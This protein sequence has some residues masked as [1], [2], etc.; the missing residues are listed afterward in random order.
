MAK[1]DTIGPIGLGTNSFN[2][3]RELQLREE[4]ERK[5]LTTRKTTTPYT[6]SSVGIDPSRIPSGVSQS[7]I[8]FAMMTPAA[9]KQARD[10]AKQLAT[11]PQLFIGINSQKLA[12]S[13]RDFD[14]LPPIHQKATYNAVTYS[15]LT[16]DEK[17]RTLEAEKQRSQNQTASQVSTIQR[18]WQKEADAIAK[19]E[20]DAR[21]GLTDQIARGA[22]NAQQNSIAG[23][24]G[25]GTPTIVK[26]LAPG[27]SVGG[28][29]TAITNPVGTYFVESTKQSPKISVAT[30]TG[31]TRTSDNATNITPIVNYKEAP[32]G[33]SPVINKLLVDNAKKFQ[34]SLTGQL[35]N[36]VYDGLAT[37]TKRPE[38]SMTETGITPIVP[39]NEIT[40]AQYAQKAQ[41]ESDAQK[42]VTE[43]YL[44]EQAKED[45]RKSDAEKAKLQAELDKQAK[46]NAELE[47][48]KLAEAKAAE[49]ARFRSQQQFDYDSQ[50]EAALRAA[51]GNSP[52]ARRQF[53]AYEDRQ[54]TMDAEKL[55]QQRAKRGNPA[56]YAGGFAQKAIQPTPATPAAIKAPAMTAPQTPVPIE[57]PANKLTSSFLPPK[58]DGLQ[59]GGT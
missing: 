48:K 4:L 52:L 33:A 29:K 11:N 20:S 49:A 54:K 19:K 41:E 58:V 44:A 43:K 36:A 21:Y 15:L 28:T 56:G 3:T 7:A 35:V 23:I 45:A 27:Q 32:V 22:T 40:P 24:S 2:P 5:V 38:Y 6:F 25:A 17:N 59:F 34:E 13:A 14:A 12:E 57:P 42:I 16:P 30:A 1:S 51:E 53:S 18:N 26:A 50:I 31:G 37:Q 9:Q 8:N 46:L 39:L 10:Y 47:A 55:A